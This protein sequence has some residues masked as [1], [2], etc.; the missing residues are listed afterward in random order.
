MCK[1]DSEDTLLLLCCSH[2]N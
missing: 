2:P 1:N